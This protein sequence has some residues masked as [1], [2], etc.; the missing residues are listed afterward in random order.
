MTEHRDQARRSNLALRPVLLAL[1]VGHAA[2]GAFM[3][4]APK[5]F[6]D[7][8]AAYGAYNDHYIRDL[9]TFYLALGALF[10]MAAARRAWQWPVLFFALVQY[11]LH[12]LNHLWDLS[13]AEP[14]W[15]GPVNVVT[16]GLTAALI[17]WAYRQAQER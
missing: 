6:F 15:Q 13:D 16:L 8:I 11:G 7:E 12:I 5:T 3:V 4:I 2:L 14:A 1:G 10:V 9:A 17:W